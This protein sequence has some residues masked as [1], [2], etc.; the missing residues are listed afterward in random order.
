MSRHCN[1]A[2][3]RSSLSISTNFLINVSLPERSLQFLEL[4]LY[5]MWMWIA[6]PAHF[7]YGRVTTRATRFYSQFQDEFSVRKCCSVKVPFAGG[8]QISKCYVMRSNAGSLQLRKDANGFVHVLRNVYGM[9]CVDLR[10]PSRSS[11]IPLSAYNDDSMYRLAKDDDLLVYINRATL[12]SNSFSKRS[13]C[14]TSIENVGVIVIRV[15]LLT[16]R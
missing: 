13:T 10:S 5:S 14:K 7:Q 6:Y 3:M 12:G 16:R 9:A 1:T 2:E 15:A 8:R 11:N 4:L